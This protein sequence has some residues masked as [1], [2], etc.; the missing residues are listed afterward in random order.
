MF[1]LLG[2]LTVLNTVIISPARADDRTQN[3][4]DCRSWRNN[5]RARRG[6]EGAHG[7]T[8]PCTG[9]A[10]ETERRETEDGERGM[11]CRLA[12]A[13]VAEMLGTSRTVVF[14]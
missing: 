6:R 11:H 9:T 4:R 10:R 2:L 13:W 3:E 1:R 12:S 7:A 14:E 8:R 5:A